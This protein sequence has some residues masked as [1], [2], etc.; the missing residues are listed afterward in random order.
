MDIFVASLIGHSGTLAP[1]VPLVP[2]SDSWNPSTAMDYGAAVLVIYY[3]QVTN[4]SDSP[5][6][7]MIPV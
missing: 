1:A 5:L 2:E 4:S 6:A 3:W 7:P